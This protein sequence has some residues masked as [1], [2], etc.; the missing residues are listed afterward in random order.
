MTGRTREAAIEEVT[1]IGVRPG[2]PEFE[3]MVDASMRGWPAWRIAQ[4]FN[5]SPALIHRLGGPAP[6]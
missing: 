4:A 3:K 6:T 5:L 1:R 2:E